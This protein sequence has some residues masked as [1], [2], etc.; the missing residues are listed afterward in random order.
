MFGGIIIEGDIREGEGG[1][2][3]AG[4][5]IH[6]IV[7]CIIFVSVSVLGSSLSLPSLPSLFC[8]F[9]PS[10]CLSLLD[11]DLLAVSLLPACAHPNGSTRDPVILMS[12][13]LTH[14]GDWVL[15]GGP[16]M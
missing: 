9:S 5:A 15:A 3:R 10:L 7:H 12:A 16:A 8:L 2:S 1:L 13:Y 14:G 6:Y 11:P 4:F